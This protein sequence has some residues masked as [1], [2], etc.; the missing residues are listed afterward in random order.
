MYYHHIMYV[1]KNQ[2]VNLHYGKYSIKYQYIVLQKICVC[3]VTT[4]MI[5]KTHCTVEKCNKMPTQSI[6]IQICKGQHTV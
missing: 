3:T 6:T 4:E 2:N 1:V 5:L